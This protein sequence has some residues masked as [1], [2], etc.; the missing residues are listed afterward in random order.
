MSVISGG[1]HL[2]SQMFGDLPND[3]D[4]VL[5]ADQNR[6]IDSDADD[7][8]SGRRNTR[9]RRRQNRGGARN[10]GG[11]GG[12]RRRNNA[13]N[14]DSDNSDDEHGSAI[15]DAIRRQ[16][17]PR[18]ELL[19]AHTDLCMDFFIMATGSLSGAIETFFT[20]QP[21]P[22]CTTFADYRRYLTPTLISC[23]EETNAKIQYESSRKM[24]VEMV[25][26]LP[27]SAPASRELRHAGATLLG[28]YIR[29]AV[30]ANP[31]RT[32]PTKFAMKTQERDENRAVLNIRKHIRRWFLTR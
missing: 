13:A 29:K 31:I 26:A 7:S 12:G 6:N 16:N 15:V 21:N 20:A 4:S 22:T 30:M 25:A 5:N 9:R 1:G 24:T 17:E 14:D 3:T 27:N 2:I 10:G 18:R 28:Q 19:I 8:E 32:V 23:W 11:G